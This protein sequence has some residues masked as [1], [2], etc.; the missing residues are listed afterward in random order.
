METASAPDIALNLRNCR[1]LLLALGL[2]LFLAL[3]APTAG[4][5]NIA[6]PTFPGSPLWEAPEPV[7][8]QGWRIQQN[9]L[10]RHW[11]LLD[12]ANIR[13]AWG[14]RAHCLA[15]FAHL[16]ADIPL[17]EHRFGSGP[18]FNIPFPT[19]G[20]KQVWMDRRV[21][22]GWRLQTNVLTGH[23]RL[24]DPHNLRIA[25]G[26]LEA[27]LREWGRTVA[28]EVTAHE[29]RAG[30]PEVIVILIHGIVRSRGTWFL[31]IRDI[32]REARRR[33]RPVE[34]WAISYPSTR[35]SIGD[36]AGHLA[37]VISALPADIP[38]VLVGHSMGGLDAH[39]YLGRRG[40]KAED[41]PHPV[42]ALVDLGTPFAG[43]PL[44]DA[45]CGSPLYQA[46]LGPAGQELVTSPTR[47]PRG[48][49]PECR[50]I[51]VAGSLPPGGFNRMIPGDD[52]GIV[53]LA[54][55]LPS[56]AA[57]HRT[58]AVPHFLLMLSGTGRKAI[59]DGIFGR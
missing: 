6:L 31:N 55:A 22:R 53:P 27:M 28:P 46:I 23:S 45:W 20:G 29:A 3:P 44:A 35:I 52:D 30:R 26:T 59:L 54:S 12:Q 19:L 56:Q 34:A 37:E 33:G 16:I 50:T 36:A 25:W 39:A 38:L 4:G 48:P 24:L 47:L 51:C 5:P 14:S 1:K 49:W 32:E 2:A 11:R 41:S 40:W 17:G 7:G 18:E 15:A 9:V 8:T 10:T 13:R 43:S 57:E 58:V 21:R 42:K